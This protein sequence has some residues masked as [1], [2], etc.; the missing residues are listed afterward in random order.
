[1]PVEHIIMQLSE[2]PGIPKLPLKLMCYQSV[3]KQ[4]FLWIHSM[5]MKKTCH[6][7]TTEKQKNWVL[8][9]ECMTNPNESTFHGLHM[10]LKTS[11]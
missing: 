4:D 1:M 11:Q 9:K 10:D 7:R 2:F 6:F 8:K 3:T 5:Y